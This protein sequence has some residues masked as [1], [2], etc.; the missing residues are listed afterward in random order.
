MNIIVAVDK[1]GGFGK[2]G[3]IPWHFKSDF[4]HFKETTAG[5]ICVMGKQTYLDMAGMMAAKGKEI[6]DEIL[7]GRKTYVISSSMIEAKG[8]TVIKDLSQVTSIHPSDEIFILG[9]ERLFLQA[10]SS[11]S[12]IYM[13]VIDGDYGCDRFFPVEYLSGR[14]NIASGRKEEESGVQLMFVEYKRVA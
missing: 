6:G 11:A 10:I 2:D 8:A 14:F 9:G 1:N 7:P 3:K 4:K 13:T 12:T 5:K